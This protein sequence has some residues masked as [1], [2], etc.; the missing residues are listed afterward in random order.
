[1]KNIYSYYNNKN[2]FCY[3][4]LLLVTISCGP[5]YN[6]PS[7]PKPVVEQLNN[8]EEIDQLIEDNKQ[9]TLQ[10][11]G[12]LS[13][14]NPRNPKSSLIFKKQNCHSINLQ[15]SLIDSVNFSESFDNFKLY[16][17]NY[18][19]KKS[20]F[21]IVKGLY[22]D[23][24][25]FYRWKQSQNIHK[26]NFELDSGI[27]LSGIFAKKNNSLNNPLVVVIPGV[28]SNFEGPSAVL[29]LMHLFDEGPFNVLV[30]NSMSSVDFQVE[31]NA[32]VFGGF[33]EGHH[34]FELI[35]ILKS[36]D[37]KK[38]NKISEVHLYGHSL[39]GQAALYAST[40]SKNNLPN[41]SGYDSIVSACPPVNLKSALHRALVNIKV[42]MFMNSKFS[43]SF[44]FLQSQ[45]PTLINRYLF[46]NV[47]PKGLKILDFTAKSSIKFYSQNLTDKNFRPPFE[48]VK[49]KDEESFWNTNDYA[50]YIDENISPTTVLYS[51]SDILID[52]K[53]HSE[54]LKALAYNKK[55][56]N[57]N[58]VNLP[59]VGHCTIDQGLNWDNSGALIRGLFINKSP[60]LK[61][62]MKRVDIDAK[63]LKIKI[64][65]NKGE[66][67]TNF[68]WKS[69]P[70][71]RTLE[72]IIQKI[73]TNENQD[74]YEFEEQYQFSLED[75]Q[76]FSFET[77][78]NYYQAQTL[79]RWLHAN[80]V[81]S[82]DLDKLGF[83]N[84]SKGINYFSWFNY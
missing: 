7:E 37:F 65:L 55:I 77:P 42:R 72:L 50:N 53:I 25:L 83:V 12:V 82:S 35:S 56:K 11:L 5:K 30:L 4:I 6:P 71:T 74:D 47:L 80:I 19:P 68:F 16:C 41:S 73:I 1:M 44:K 20:K 52:S 18:F 22:K 66:L 31:N 28:C 67:I 70:G 15:N 29:P 60:S 33:E 8:K 21:Q 79:E 63:S 14:L 57:M 51:N 59:N 13:N 17:E 54:S 58:F 27:K 84:T 9:G 38:K 49:I 34:L 45:F 36:A 24:A 32:M 26:I 2:N 40:L 46:E 81:F 3:Y 23:A 61:N 10:S 76:L 39:G 75:L 62:R 64:N 43:G 48:D 69:L 78:N